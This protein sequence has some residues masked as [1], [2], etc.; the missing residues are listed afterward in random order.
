MLPIV[1]HQDAVSAGLAGAGEGLARRRALLTEAG[2]EA[3]EIALDKP[4]PKG[5]SVLFVAG[6]GPEVSESLAI[7]ARAR[8][9]LVNVEDVPRL[10][11]FHVPATIRRGD[12][13]I[14]VSTGG[15]APG[16][17]RLVR[18]WLEAKIGIEWSGRLREVS[19]SRA[20]WRA[21]GQKPAEVSKRLR[22]YV[23]ERGWL[24]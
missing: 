9:I 18:E 11:D 16:L 20:K 17:A 6:L 21:A 2:L 5:L 14:T 8:D 7:Q 4:L 12:L 1:L 23:S 13:V 10:C 19:Q 15:K 24:S 3:I 22:D